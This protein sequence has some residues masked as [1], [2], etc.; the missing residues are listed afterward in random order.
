MA[1]RILCCYL[2]HLSN[3]S[4]VSDSYRRLK[5]LVNNPDKFEQRHYLP[6]FLITQYQFS[7]SILVELINLLFLTR[8]ATLIDLIMNYVAFEGVSQIDNLYTASVRN[9]KAAELIPND[10]LPN[11]TLDKLRSFEKQSNKVDSMKYSFKNP[12]PTNN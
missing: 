8:Q 5:F 1:L 9:L 11:P 4:D 12:V 3:Y 6:A 10:A 7:A 2:F